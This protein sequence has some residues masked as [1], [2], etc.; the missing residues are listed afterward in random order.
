MLKDKIV[1]V[2]GASRGIGRATALAFAREGAKVIINY[3]RSK[4]LAEEIVEEIRGESGIAVAIQANVGD[5]DAV[6]KMVDKS[7][8]EFGRVDIL[9]NNAGVLMGS[10]S[11]FDFNDNEFTLMWQV[12]VKG[13]LYCSQAI[14]PQMIENHYGKIVNIAS[15]AGLGTSRLPGNM[16]YSSTKAAVVILT[17]RLALEFGKYGIN[18][19]AIAPGLIRTDMGLGNRSTAE[20]EEFLKYFEEKSI[21]Q[22]IGE[23]EEVANA[24]IFL[25]SDKASFITGQVLTVDGGRIDFISHSL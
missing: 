13:I 7:L 3:H 20:Q 9:I 17:K 16:L 15:I 18:V 1:L 14:V 22:R 2:T 5:R 10:G 21:L 6:K 4:S 12:N 25:A 8:R 23:P 19:N 24:A 11:L